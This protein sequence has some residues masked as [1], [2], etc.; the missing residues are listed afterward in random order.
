MLNYQSYLKWNLSHKIGAKCNEYSEEIAQRSKTPT[1]CLYFF[2][3]VK[4]TNALICKKA[5]KLSHSFA[6]MG[7]CTYGYQCNC[8]NQM[9]SQ[10][11]DYRIKLKVGKTSFFK[12]H[13]VV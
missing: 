10:T 1:I 2:P 5:K 13:R 4:P 12:H 7:N 9:F 6:Q 3:E 11:D 8:E